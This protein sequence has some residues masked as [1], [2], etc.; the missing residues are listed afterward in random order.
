[1]MRLNR[2]FLIIVLLG[3]GLHTRAQRAMDTLPAL[4]TLPEFTIYQLKNG[5]VWLG[6]LNDYGVVK[7]ITIQRSSDSLRRYASIFSSPNPMAR[8]GDFTDT[9]PVKG[10]E[11]FYRV[12]VQLPE[13]QYFYTAPQRAIP[14]PPGTLAMLDYPPPPTAKQ[15]KGKPVKGKPGNTETIPVN[16]SSQVVVAGTA[17]ITPPKPPVFVPSDYIFSDRKGNIIINLPGAE[18]KQYSIVFRDEAGREL[19]KIGKV[20]ESN[21]VMERSNFYR[22]GWYYFEIYEGEA[23]F[24]KHKVLLPKE[25][26]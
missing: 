25:K 24:E 19:F 13:G 2:L 12:F 7:Q 5:T 17:V 16:D 15:V 11:F 4:D 21:L 20:K 14:L 10:Y 26:P 3:A 23:L 8:R 6:W 1:M 18:T 9:K 22:S